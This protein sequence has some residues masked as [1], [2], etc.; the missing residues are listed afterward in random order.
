M[1][2]A[3]SWTASSDIARAVQWPADQVG[4]YLAADRPYGWHR[5]LT[6]EGSTGDG[7][8]GETLAEQLK[9]LAE[10]GLVLDPVAAPALRLDANQLRALRRTDTPGEHA[11]LVRGSNIEGRN[12]V[13]AWLK[14][15]FVS[16]AA[17]GIAALPEPVTRDAIEAAVD[18][19]T[20][21]RAGDYRRRRVEEYDRFLRR[22][23]IGDFVLTTSGGAVHVGRIA[24]DAEWVVEA[25]KGGG[26]IRV[27]RAVQW[28][29][30]DEGIEFTE[31]PAPLP[32]RLGTPDDVADLTLEYATIA[33][34]FPG[35]EK[36]DDGDGDDIDPRLPPSQ[37]CP[38]P[39]KNWPSDC[40]STWI[41]WSGSRRC[42]NA[43]TR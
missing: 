27:R 28:I 17:T 18:A 42:W 43:V 14:G 21:N 30:D 32:D 36:E 39:P 1:V 40:S 37:V 9:L 20:A 22:I 41:G 25:D 8:A 16:R 35:E 12:L 26:P 31:L 15:G 5:V 34:L 13:G 4:T 33:A 38:H 7:V 10:D 11:W 3:G 24:G 19:A 23:G 29:T 6:S 2:P